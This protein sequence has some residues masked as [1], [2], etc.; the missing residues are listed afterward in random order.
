MA[1]NSIDRPPLFELVAEAVTAWRD[2]TVQGAFE[3]D[4]G[5][6]LRLA[7]TYGQATGIAEQLVRDS[8]DA[9]RHVGLRL[10]GFICDERPDQCA[11][12]ATFLTVELPRMSDASVRLAAIDALGKTK[13]GRAVPVLLRAAT[14]NEV[15]ERVAIVRALTECSI[16]APTAPAVAQL[17]RAME[18]AAP[19]VRQWATYGIG[20]CLQI[21]TTQIREALAKRL[22]DEDEHARVEAIRGLARRRDLRSIEA[23]TAA[24]ANGKCADEIVDSAQ[25]LAGPRLWSLVRDLDSSDDAALRRLQ[26]L[27]DPARRTRQDERLTAFIDALATHP[28][29]PHVSVVCNRFGLSV[30]V[31]EL[32]TGVMVSLDDFLDNDDPSEEAI[33]QEVERIFVAL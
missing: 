24:L 31:V 15:G 26:R 11:Q 25:Y 32:S 16:D 14:L 13:D 27:C 9:R 30:E 10:L 5:G 29:A 4:F 7:A 17:L 28:D 2:V 6:R 21:D 8:D 1:V 3:H 33:G 18:D 20:T 23:I 22:F 12:I 19:A